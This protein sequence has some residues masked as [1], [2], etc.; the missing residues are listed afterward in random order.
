MVKSAKKG[1]VLMARYS[2]SQK[3]KMGKRIKAIRQSLN[4]D[5]CEFGNM[6][7]PKA[8]ASN[9]SR[10]ERGL[11]VPN[12]S[13]IISIAKIGQVSTSFLL[14]GPQA[15]I[16]D[17]YNKYKNFQNHIFNN[18]EIKEIKEI[19]MENKIEN[20]TLIGDATPL[21]E[22]ITGKVFKDDFISKLPLGE[23]L[24]AYQIS[25]LFNRISYTK[26]PNKF[27]EDL[28][29]YLAGIAHLISRSTSKAE[30]L[31]LQ[32]KFNDSINEIFK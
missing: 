27:L 2:E 4:L 21:F 7:T 1:G 16:E 19:A 31:E 23:R 25:I 13:R 32:D 18:G 12:T 10:W 22:A 9:V 17:L 8:S 6:V 29:S 30:F 20:K 14:N 24:I 11:N 15:N 3:I 28:A 26:V 5:Q